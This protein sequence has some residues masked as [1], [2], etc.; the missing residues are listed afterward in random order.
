MYPDA[1]SEVERHI[2]LRDRSHD[3]IPLRLAHIHQHVGALGLE[4]RAIL[5]FHLALAG[6]AAELVLHSCLAILLRHLLAG[7]SR[8]S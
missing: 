8:Q 5:V 3:L 6:L 7:R 4:K 1:F 2:L